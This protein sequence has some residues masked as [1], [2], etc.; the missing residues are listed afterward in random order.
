MWISNQ[1]FLEKYVITYLSMDWPKTWEDECQNT[2]FASS[3]SH[4]NNIKSQSPSNGLVK[5]HNLP[6]TFATIHAFANP[7]D[8][9]SAICNG[10]VFNLLPSL[11]VPSDNLIFIASFGNFS[12]SWHCLW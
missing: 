10:V 7:L 4:F 1:K 12:R 5:S 8:I 11:I 3:S 2:C 9:P 6:S